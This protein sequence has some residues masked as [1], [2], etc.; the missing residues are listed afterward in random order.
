M[1]PTAAA[2]CDVI[3]RRARAWSSG[4]A[5]DGVDAIAVKDGAIVA[6]GREADLLPLAGPATRV[7]D[8]AHATVT[9][10]LTDAHLH[11]LAWA[12]GALELDV[13]GAG[14]ARE[15]AER[16]RT[17][18]AGHP[19]R[20]VIVGRGWDAHGWPDA[21]G[22]EVL[23]RAVNDRPVILHAHDFHT[24][25]VNSRALAEA[26]IRRESAD[27]E[28]G[29]IERDGANEP[30]GVLREH[31]VRALQ[32]VEARAP[33]ADGVA[34]LRHAARTL[35]AR[36]ITAVHD[37]E[38]PESL[39]LLRALATGDGP[40]LRVLAHL[41]QSSLD[42]ACALGL[43]S[44]V[45][46]D[47]FRIA[48]VK[49]FADGTLGSRTAAMLEPYEGGG[50]GMELIPHDALAALV[51]RAFA[52]GLSVAIHAIGDRAVRSALDAYQ[53][54]GAARARVALPPRI[55]H[56]QLA[57]PADLARFRALGVAASVQPAFVPSD[58]EA[59]RRWWGAR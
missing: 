41:P 50:T 27:P 51:A 26:G 37:F 31:A 52:A 20:G 39:R 23:D 22:R 2:G 46:D 32:P 59:A 9:P 13:A 48:G 30:T 56:V 49:L 14:S 58:A 44:G 40:R 47:F 34:A 18:A 42:A 6:L 1:R 57:H 29:R 33:K 17:F 7:L 4:A 25:W 8:A 38:G 21:P 54:A 19:D 45:G 11:L 12:R 43:E 35:L 24:A 16:V 55:E 36:G 5:L 3:V 28:G 53:A 15:V 10:G